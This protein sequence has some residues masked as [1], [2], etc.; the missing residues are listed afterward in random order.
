MKI[1]IKVRQYL[2]LFLI[3]GIAS[4]HLFQ[5]CTNMSKKRIFQQIEFAW[6]GNCQENISIGLSVEAT[7]VALDSPFSWTW[8]I[9]NDGDSPVSITL[10]HELDRLYRCR[11]QILRYGEQKPLHEFFQPPA[12][13]I[14]KTMGNS[15][16]SVLL[17]KGMIETRYGGKA[18]IDKSWGPGIYQVRVIFGGDSFNFTCLSGVINIV[19]K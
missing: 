6:G 19:A 11:L 16:D 3:S 14:H 15:V 10:R 18:G 7:E 17:L 5:S 13:V 1:N 2:L 9:K 4:I 12:N 8:A